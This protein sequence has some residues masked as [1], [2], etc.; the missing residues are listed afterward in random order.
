MEKKKKM[1]TCCDEIAKSIVDKYTEKVGGSKRAWR[2]Q[3]N[4]DR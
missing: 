2:V 1:D 3:V 4:G